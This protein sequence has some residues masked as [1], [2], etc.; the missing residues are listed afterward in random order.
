MNKFIIRR[1]GTVAAPGVKLIARGSVKGNKTTFRFP[2]EAHP[3]TPVL[4]DRV[5]T[6]TGDFLNTELSDRIVTG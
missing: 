1:N 3:L 6:E 4:G 2:K 5:L